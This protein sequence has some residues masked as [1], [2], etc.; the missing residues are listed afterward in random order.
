MQ[1]D[2]FEV[3]IFKWSSIFFQLINF[4]ALITSTTE[5]ELNTFLR[6]FW[7]GVTDDTIQMVILGTIFIL[8]YQILVISALEK[9]FREELSAYRQAVREFDESLD[10]RSRTRFPRAAITLQ[11]PRLSFSTS[12]SDE[13][14][15][16]DGLTPPPTYEEVSNGF[17]FQPKILSENFIEIKVENEQKE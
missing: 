9:E 14:P 4:I 10:E 3:G 8:T 7:K 6:H 2:A 17:L 11:I 12:H 16:Y 5:S 1:H 13:P 15:N